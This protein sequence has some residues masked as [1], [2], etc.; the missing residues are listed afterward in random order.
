LKSCAE[1]GY[2]SQYRLNPEHIQDLTKEID[3][4]KRGLKKAINCS[5]FKIIRLVTKV[6]PMIIKIE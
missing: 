3:G 6:L 4:R 2:D 5:E 1:L